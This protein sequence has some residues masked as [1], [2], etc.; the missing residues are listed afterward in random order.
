MF[1]THLEALGSTNPLQ[2]CPPEIEKMESEIQTHIQRKDIPSALDAISNAKGFLLEGDAARNKLADLENRIGLCLDHQVAKAQRSTPIRSIK[3]PGAH[4]WAATGFQFAR[5]TPPLA[6]LMPQELVD[7][8]NQGTVDTDDIVMAFANYDNELSARSGFSFQND[9]ITALRAMA[10]SAECSIIDHFKT[11]P[12]NVSFNKTTISNGDLFIEAHLPLQQQP[13]KTLQKNGR[14]FEL[15]NC[16]LRGGGEGVSN[17]GHYRT[18]ISQPDGFHFVDDN[19]HYKWDKDR[20]WVDPTTN[21]DPRTN[22]AITYNQAHETVALLRPG[23][24]QQVNGT[25]RIHSR[26]PLTAFVTPLE[27]LQEKGRM[28]Y[29]Q[30]VSSERSE[31]KMRHDSKSRASSSSSASYKRTASAS[32]AATNQTTTKCNKTC[33]GILR[34]FCSGAYQGIRFVASKCCG[35]RPAKKDS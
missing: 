22:Q 4:C 12:L 13:P 10:E 18:F 1:S 32:P 19:F 23:I 7:A 27:L 20:G 26:A 34:S 8:Y 5:H 29:Y 11:T 15:K 25:Q 17:S 9:P 3:N 16:I 31:G 24:I 33:L 2:G 21:V 28:F 6:R 14:T 30:E 35:E